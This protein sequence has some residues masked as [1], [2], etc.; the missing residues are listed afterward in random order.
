MGEQHER[1]CIIFCI[2][3]AKGTDGIDI[4]MISK[5]QTTSTDLQL[6]CDIVK[7]VITSPKT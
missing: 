5:V 7:A 4:V 3:I 2:S 1:L 6:K